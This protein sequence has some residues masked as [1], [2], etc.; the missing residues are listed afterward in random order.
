MKRLLVILVKAGLLLGALAVT[1]GLAAWFTIAFFADEKH[2]VTVP[3]LRGLDTTE[4]LRKVN[5]LGLRLVVDDA[6]K[7]QYDPNVPFNHILRQD[8]P[9]GSQIKT[10]R[11]VRVLLSLGAHNLYVPQV[12][13]LTAPAAQIKLHEAGIT[14][15][16]LVYAHTPRTPEGTVLAQEAAGDGGVI[17][18]LVSG[19]VQDAV[20]VAP[21]LIGKSETAARTLLESRRFKV[22]LEFES[23]PGLPE[24]TVIRQKPQAGYPLKANDVVSL[25]VSKSG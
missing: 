21:D 3:E 12:V 19:G 15:G 18:L 23:Y 24:G 14:V 4:A 5:E 17:N 22:K 2:V 20:Y 7:S 25:W 11:K 9:A 16:D 6:S 10:D 13:G 1:A 8:P